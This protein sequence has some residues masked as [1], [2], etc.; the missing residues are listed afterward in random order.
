MKAGPLLSALSAYLSS[1]FKYKVLFLCICLF[2]ADTYVMF[3]LMMLRKMKYRKSQLKDESQDSP[4][5]FW[6]I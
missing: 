5:L 1:S 2:A 4:G 3:Y 6:N